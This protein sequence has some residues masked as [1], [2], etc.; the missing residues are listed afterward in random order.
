MTG[1]NKDISKAFN[2]FK[3][4]SEECNARGEFYMGICLLRSLSINKNEEQGIEMLKRS[5]KQN[6]QKTL[7]QLGQLYEDRAAN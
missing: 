3:S 7:R 6:N 5:A 1:E 2:M 4:A